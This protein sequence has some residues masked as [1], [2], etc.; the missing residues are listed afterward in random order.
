MRLSDIG[1]RKAAIG[2]LRLLDADAKGEE[3]AAEP[4]PPA[5][6]L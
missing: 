5:Y 6:K 4:P 3:I 1:R 2:R